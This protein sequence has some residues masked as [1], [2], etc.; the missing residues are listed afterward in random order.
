MERKESKVC[1]KTTGI[2][3]FMAIPICGLG[4][5]NLKGKLI[6][7]FLLL[8]FM[9]SNL[10]V[11]GQQNEITGMVKD[12][13]TGEN[14]LGVNVVIKG[15]TSGTVTDI[16]G[17][18]SLNVANTNDTLQISYIG[19]LDEIVPIGGRSVIEVQL[20]PD[21]EA[22]D[23][24]VVVGYG[25]MRKSDV[26]GAIVSID[27]EDFTQVKTTNVIESLQGKA[28]GV[29]ITRSSGEAGSGF[30]VLI[31]GE[32]SLSGS[33]TPLYIVDGV[34][35]GSGIDINP[36]DIES[37]E[38]LKDV[39][40]TAIYGAK[41]ANGVIIITTKQGI[42][43]KS[44][45][46]FSA[47]A[48]LNKPMG[49]LPYM[50]GS[51]YLKFKDDLTKTKEYN[52]TGEWIDTL[53]PEYVP[54]VQRGI[55]N[56]TNTNW[57]DEVKRNG[58]LQNYYLSVY[59][60]KEGISYN[61]SLDYTNETG[62]LKQDDYKRYLIKGGMDI[63]VNKHLNVGTSNILSFR[64]RNR[65]D[66]SEKSIRLMNPFAEPYDSAGNLNTHPM[67]P[68][69]EFLTPLWYHQDGYYTHEELTTRIFSNVY[70]N[71]KI[72]EGLNFRSTFNLDYATYREGHSERAGE[73]DVNVYM[74]IKPSKDY[75]WTNILTFDRTFGIHHLQVTGVHEMLWGGAERY[76]ISGR[77]PSIDNSLWYAPSSWD[78]T[79]ISV[80]LDPD[81]K[82]DD[83]FYYSEG[84]QLAFLGRINYGLLGR[85]IVTASL[86][87]DG[88]SRLAEGNKWDYFPS[89]SVAWNIAEENFLKQ[90]DF[91]SVLK[92]RLS[93]GV[94]G[95]YSVPVY[96]SIDRVNT[97]PLYF[98]FGSPEQVI[99][100]YRPVFAGNPTLGWE[101][102]TSF[103][104]GLDFGII[105]NRLSG[106]IDLYTAK[107]T[108]LLQ[109][110]VL[111]PHAAIPSIYDNVGETQTKGVELMLHSIL[112]S[113]KK[114]G[115]LKWTADLSLTFNHEEIVALASGVQK[116]EANG[117]FVG[118]PI[119]VWFDYEKTGI[120]QIADSVEMQM[121]V[122]NGME[123]QAG[124]IKIKDQPD[125]VTGQIDTVINEA[126]RVVL[127]QQRPKW[128]GS[129]STRFEYKGFDLSLLFVGRFGHT[130][131]DNVMNQFQVRDD[132]AESGMVVDYWTPVNPT[133]TAPRMDPSISAINYMPYSSSLL[134]TDGSWIKIRDITLGYTLPSQVLDKI[135]VSSL[136]I[137]VS[138]QNAFV[139][140]SPLW[141][142]GR[143]DPEKRGGTSW[144]TPRTYLVG[145]TLDF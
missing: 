135:K 59:G 44:K 138:A 50:E 131:R 49:K 18:F 100:G 19:Y 11:Y 17:N 96:S 48:G 22:L 79:S 51:D 62:M 99:F 29:D 127:G 104:V 61:V 124:D 80:Q 67:S 123:L 76:R 9:L 13:N 7:G 110:R 14:L 143:Y 6:A 126:D 101:K 119:D 121:Y 42:E 39:A 21:I 125:P 106:N 8:F 40:S 74:Y 83:A 89:A 16:D 128:Y 24:V 145:L 57:F 94:S 114:A 34:Q 66:F 92:L 31:R 144:P 137:Y 69:S 28:A 93:Y 113:P 105:N 86:R 91:L 140:Y 43:G 98:E 56:G 72:I 36:S 45:I 30:S 15:T 35:Y 58:Y 23:E 108:D 133:N 81:A 75:T 84:S 141:D 117:W 136:R 132:Y 78:A 95:N 130:V 25:T 139:L 4:F 37:I 82:G 60:G 10:T 90:V 122:D 109:Q 118:E 38:I 32:R 68:T 73:E 85:Y 107:T 26:T 2:L 116:D 52:R 88:S 12:A 41:G 65:M 115:G 87:Y 63:E 64:D 33:N 27:E 77:N 120:W 20:V 71:V 129:F 1:F 111:P 47:Y 54:F 3:A 46:T 55:A 5:K 142:R 134:Y 53:T 97:D 70:A 112:V 103:N 102:T